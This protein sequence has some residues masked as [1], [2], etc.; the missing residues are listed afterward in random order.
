MA[1]ILCQMDIHPA[2]RHPMELA[3][4]DDTMNERKPMS[5]DMALPSVFS[6]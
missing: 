2:C 1:R 3:L 4:L 5:C 6:F